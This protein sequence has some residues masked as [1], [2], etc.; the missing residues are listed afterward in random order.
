MHPAWLH[1]RTSISAGALRNLWKLGRYS[2]NVSIDE[3]QG[4]L[5]KPQTSASKSNIAI[6]N[7]IRWGQESCSSRASCTVIRLTSRCCRLPPIDPISGKTLAS[8]SK[9]WMFSTRWLI[10]EAANKPLNLRAVMVLSTPLGH[11]YVN[12]RSEEK[13]TSLISRKMSSRW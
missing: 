1:P 5:Q 12:L 10:F 3:K 11:S 8:G 9:R 4:I 6:T 2:E 13:L 7:D